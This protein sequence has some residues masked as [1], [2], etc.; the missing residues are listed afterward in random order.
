MKL[1]TQSVKRNYIFNT[2]YQILSICVPL[3]TA[4]YLSRTLGAD[5]IGVQSYTN[6]IIAYFTM[7]CVLGST[8]FGQRK[9]AME[10]DDKEKLS[11]A[12]WNIVCFRVFMVLITL[13]V[14]A[15]FWVK[16][17]EYKVIFGILIH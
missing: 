11:T 16:V 15:V 3:I 17:Q 7:V 10:R 14:Y 1:K 5:G 13:G 12:F 9:I 4:P 8:T 6:S 2:A